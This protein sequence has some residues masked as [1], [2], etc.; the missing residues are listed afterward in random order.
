MPNF[1]NR[2]MA[3]RFIPFGMIL[4]SCTVLLQCL[5]KKKNNQQENP[6]PEEDP[7]DS[8]TE[9]PEQTEKEGDK[10]GSEQKPSDK[11][12]DQ[13]ANPFQPYKP[14]CVDNSNQIAIDKIRDAEEAFDPVIKLYGL[15]SSAMVVIALPKYQHSNLKD[16]FLLSQS[17]KLL[18][19]KGISEF[20][21]IDLDKTLKPIFFDNL[22]IGNNRRFALLYQTIDNLYSKHILGEPSQ[23][24]TTFKGL[25]A[26]GLTPVSVPTQD[27]FK[28]HINNIV[29]PIKEQFDY[30][31]DPEAPILAGVDTKFHPI[32]IDKNSHIT[33]L[34]GR[35]LITENGEF[36]D[37]GRY[38]AFIHY[39]L[40]KEYYL[41]TIVKIV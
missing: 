37:F 34:I 9:E 19:H 28:S 10:N 29:T 35:E 27:Y 14:H 36:N 4:G 7:Q 12:N 25:K 23:F 5:N 39:K 32:T 31:Q 33:D 24:E 18:A 26:Y 3:M 30:Q 16:I 13:T 22:F 11:E 40:V 20:S 2:R 41:R 8:P 38:N 15:E 1:I 21:D 17:G 6:K